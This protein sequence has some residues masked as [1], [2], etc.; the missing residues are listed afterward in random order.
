MLV[1]LAVQ[2]LTGPLM[3]WSYGRDIEVFDWF[4]IPSPMEAA[5]GF[6]SMLHSLHAASALF[7]F[8]AILLHIGGVY[9][10][11]AFNQDGTLA[12]M[13]VPGRQSAAS[14]AA[15]SRAKNEGES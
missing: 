12:K 14:S 7:L 9:K 1:A 10:H 15:P 4:V 13:I 11:T 8:F 6:A 3:Q 5:F 2:I